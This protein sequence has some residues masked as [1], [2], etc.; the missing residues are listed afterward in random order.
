MRFSGEQSNDF[1]YIV[2]II[3]NVKSY[4]DEGYSVL[5]VDHTN[6][7]S[8]CIKNRELSK[9]TKEKKATWGRKMKNIH[10]KKSEHPSGSFLPPPPENILAH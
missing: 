8:I 7:C 6:G 9:K 2:Y 5:N 4:I 3:Q 1:L 10:T